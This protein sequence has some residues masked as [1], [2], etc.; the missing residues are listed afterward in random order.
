MV[1]NSKSDSKNY[2]KS[3][4]PKS[5]E[6]IART[7]SRHLD[8]FSWELSPASII[9]RQIAL[10]SAQINDQKELNKRQSQSMLQV[11][12][13]I[14]TELMQ[15][16]ERTPRYSPYRFPEREKLQKR[17]FW[18]ESD[19]RKLIATHEEKMQ[20]LHTRLLELLQ[21]HAQLDI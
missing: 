20:V 3:S 4:F 15:M 16:E 18:L 21:Q 17:L 8:N 10:V 14:N 9:K 6:E 1:T 12:C 2:R 5:L 19:R 11:E 7:L 13:Y